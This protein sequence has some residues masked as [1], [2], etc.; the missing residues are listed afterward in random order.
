MTST[1]TFAAFCLALAGCT[2]ALG[3][4]PGTPPVPAL[5]V[6]ERD[7]TAPIEVERGRKLT[8][9]LEANHS[10]GYR[11]SLAV[12]AGGPLKQIGEPFYATERPVPGAGGAEYWSFV[13]TRSGK[14]E[15]RFEYRRPWERDK[16]AVRTLSYTV[17]VR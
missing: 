3:Q 1:P 12:P 10:T 16:P 4:V 8:L 5:M 9:R 13:G 11:W 14:E 15:L 7:A 2:G 6:S 17:H